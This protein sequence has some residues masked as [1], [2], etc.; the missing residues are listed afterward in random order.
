MVRDLIDWAVV[1]LLSCT[2]MYCHVPVEFMITTGS[3]MDDCEEVFS[4]MREM[5]GIRNG[6]NLHIVCNI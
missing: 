4:P 3:R 1:F 6:S 2:V 5:V